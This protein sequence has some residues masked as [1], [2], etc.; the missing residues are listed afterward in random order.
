MKKYP[1][2]H[3]GFRPVLMLQGLFPIKIFSLCSGSARL[4]SFELRLITNEITRAEHEDKS[5]PFAPLNSFVPVGWNI[6]IT[7]TQ[8][9]LANL[10]A[11]DLYV[12]IDKR[13]FTGQNVFL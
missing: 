13:R 3:G 12:F 4:I 5:I 11:C 6:Y 8:E 2:K 9:S 10:G 1:P 7:F